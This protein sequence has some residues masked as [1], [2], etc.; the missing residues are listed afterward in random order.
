M[1]KADFNSSCPYSGPIPD[2]NIATFYDFHEI[3]PE[4]EEIRYEPGA[5]LLFRCIDIGKFFEI[6]HLNPWTTATLVWKRGTFHF[7]YCKLY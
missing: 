7:Q 4:S 6:V 5:E 2:G 1:S 3:K